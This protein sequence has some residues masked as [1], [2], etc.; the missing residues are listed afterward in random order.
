MYSDEKYDVLK[1]NIHLNLCH[2]YL[3]VNDYSNA[4][5]EAHTLK[6]NFTLNQQTDFLV[7]Q[8]L[9]EAYCMLG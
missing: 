1:R 3:Q 9:A 4:I 5:K 2:L 7:K 6:R 8:Y